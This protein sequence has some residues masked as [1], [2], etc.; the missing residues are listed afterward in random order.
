MD[1]LFHFIVLISLVCGSFSHEGGED[2]ISYSTEDF[3]SQVPNKNHF[4]MFYA[5]WCEHCKRLFP[6]W[7]QLTQKFASDDAS[8]IGIA[9]VDCTVETA[10]LKF[11]KVGENEGLKFRGTRDISSLTSFVFEQLGRKN[12]EA[13]QQ[14]TPASTERLID[15]S[16]DNFNSHVANGKHFVKFYAPWCGHCQKLAPTWEELAHSDLPQTKGVSVGKVDCTMNRVLC[17]TLD[18]KG[19]PTMLWFEDG[20]KTEKY[21]GSRS[22]EDL[23]E[24]VSRMASGSSSEEQDTEEAAMPK[25]DEEQ[26]EGAG[27]PDRVLILTGPSFDTVVWALQA[28][29]ANMGGAGTQ[30]VGQRRCESGQGGLHSG[31]QQGTLQLSGGGWFPYNLPVP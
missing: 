12:T 18:I 3:K 25:V 29:G 21:Q 30:T 31:E 1:K 28:T 16:E 5:P 10:L 7:G 8:D 4:V 6:V 9:R 22:L 17:N 26:G 2:S 15:L 13:G 27:S 20:K 11:F 23:L 14:D 19:Y 24:F